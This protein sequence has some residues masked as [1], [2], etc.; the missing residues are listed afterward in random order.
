M[1]K[2]NVIES[3]NVKTAEEKSEDEAIEKLVEVMKK[4]NYPE[5]E[6]DKGEE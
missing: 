4:A 5:V 6:E 3:S 1:I 2:Y